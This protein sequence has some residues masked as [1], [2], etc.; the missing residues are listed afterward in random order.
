MGSLT[1][2]DYFPWPEEEQR[3][4]QRVSVMR[5]LGVT[6]AFGVTL[7]P[8]PR[9]LT[10]LEKLE[11]RAAS[12]DTPEARRDARV[13]AAREEIRAKLGIWDLSPEQCDR[14]LDPKVFELE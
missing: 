9:R 3:L 14:M 2:W 4:R 7:G 8:A 10:P 5:E 11:E 12:E 1:G 13:E 6:S